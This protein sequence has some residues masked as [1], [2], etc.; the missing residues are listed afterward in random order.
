MLSGRVPPSPLL[1]KDEVLKEI[2]HIMSIENLIFGVNSVTVLY[3]IMTVHYK[4][5]RVLLQNETECR[6]YRI[7]AP[8]LIA[9]HLTPQLSY[10][11]YRYLKQT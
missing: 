8:S 2:G 9:P 11:E 1:S 4:M 6:K 10:R 3:L 5:R 7:P